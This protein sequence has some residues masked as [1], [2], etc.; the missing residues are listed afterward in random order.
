MRRT[1]RREFL[2]VV[3][4]GLAA[5]GAS[6]LARAAARPVTAG[7]GKPNIIFIMSDDCSRDWLGCYGSKENV[8]PNLD[9]LAAGGMRFET[10]YVTAICTPTRN[11]LLTG[12][13]PFRTGWIKHHDAPRWGGQFFDWKREVTFGRVVKKAGY[14]T[15]IGGKW[16]I[17]DLRTHPDALEKHGFDE[18]CL[19]TG[20]ETGNPP[21][22]ARYW[23]GYLVTN[24][25]RKVHEFGPTAVC[26]FVLDFIT[27]HKDGPFLVYYPM[28]LAHGPH[29]ST[30]LNKDTLDGKSEK[31]AAYRGQV[32]YIDHCIG[33]L[34]A[35]LD[36]LGIRRNT[37]VFYTGDNGSSAGGNAWGGEN[38]A[39]GAGGDL[40]CHTPL[41]A[42]WPGTIA[43]GQVTEELSD[44]TDMLPTFAELAGTPLPEGVK[45]DGQSIV[46]LLTGKAGPRREWIFS[47]VGSKR[48]ARDKQY[49][50]HVDGK[51]YDLQADPYEKNDLSKSTD[52]KAA[53]AREK[54]QKVLDSFPEDKVLEGFPERYSKL[55]KVPD[56][57]A[58]SG[59]W[60]PF[61]SPV[62]K[63]KKKDKK[64][65]GETPEVN[66]KREQR[67]ARKQKQQ[68]PAE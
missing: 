57:P 38:R 12:R 15:A 63:D 16:Q 31:G 4:A 7:S 33:R 50:L 39:K 10:F 61:I 23:D 58:G 34:I 45:L 53:A 19:W 44:A 13:Y 21:S 51:F 49:I 35:K 54:L 64:P 14:A 60:K 41:I 48:K 36:E 62:K 1:D 18:H 47:Q 22:H 43:P 40:G 46:S 52:A 27:R 42:N 20:F 11:M 37:L 25:E 59:K 30:P 68:P 26:D 6:P 5:A 66:A 56:L 8:T 65:K 55:G 32:A 3:G 28:M 2:R 9:K 24:R 17:N 67:K 29:T